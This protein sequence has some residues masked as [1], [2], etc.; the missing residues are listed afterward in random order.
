MN[1]SGFT[2]NII[3]LTGMAIVIGVLVNNAI[4]ILENVNGFLDRGLEPVEAAIT[5]TRDIALAIFSST[6]TN[7]VVFLPIAFMGE[8]IGRFF[9]E[10]GLTVVYATVVSLAVSFSLTPMMCGLLLKPGREGRKG[11]SLWSRIGYIV[12]FG[13]LADLWRSGFERLRSFYRWLLDACMAHRVTTLAATFVAFLMS[14]GGFAIVGME[15]FPS[16][17]EGRFVVF[18]EA[19]V[20]TPLDVTDRAVRRVEEEVARLEHLVN[21]T[22]RVGRMD[23]GGSGRNEGVDLAQVSVTVVDRAEREESLDDILNALRPRLAVI[24]TVKIRLDKE[25]GGPGEA[26]INVEIVGDDLNDMD[27]IAED[28][29]GLVRSVPGTAGVKKSLESGQPEVQ[30]IIDQRQANR[31]GL[32][33]SHISTEVRSYIEG[34]QAAEFLDGDEN[35]DVVCKLREED[36]NWATDIQ[37]LFISSPETGRQIRLGQVAEI[38]RTSGTA[39]ITRKDRR[40]LISVTANLTGDRPL[41]KVQADLARL[42]EEEVRPPEGITIG[43]GGEVEIMQK[44][45]AELFKAMATAIILT[46]LCVAGIIE[47]FT[48]A[49]IILASVPICLIGVSLALVLYNCTINMFSLMA[50]VILVG[51]VV[52]NSIIVIDYASRLRSAGEDARSAIREACV[53]R[54]RMILMANMTTIVALIPL[55]LGLGFGGEI[56]RPLAVV[57]IGGV[58]AAAGLSLLV[59]PV[60]YTIVDDLKRHCRN[61]VDDIMGLFRGREGAA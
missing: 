17:D 53:S 59:V 14:F 4:L 45:F 20:G 30:I 8:I 23:A 6:A 60:V 34:A 57:Q 44:N 12:G 28:V 27:L 36:R 2:L 11:K 43:Y 42:I 25:A 38:R 49:A 9:K 16:P 54:F 18:L 41:G 39:L 21:Y 48:L 55:S 22:V 58:G 50:M 24:P 3:S 35:Y 7:L 15:F 46:F 31:Q 40:R 47:S 56:F 10:L 33:K 52:N 19:P 51:M 61:A 13:W 32:T 29:T 5:G 37:R 1:A 26:P